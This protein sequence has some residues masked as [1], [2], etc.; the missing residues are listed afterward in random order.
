MVDEHIPSFIVIDDD[1]VNNFIC[2]KIILMMFAGADIKNFTDSRAGLDYILAAYSTTV[3][4]T[5]ILFLD[6]NM[7]GLNGWEVLELF[8]DFPEEV[9]QQI[10]IY[11][12]SSS[13]A[14]DDKL[15]AEQNPLVKG[16]ILKP[17]TQQQ[18]KELLNGNAG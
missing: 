5:S 10:S 11:M 12:F 15:R 13:I 9:K 2:R 18:L 16:F 7:P 3:S 14:M 8:K 6:I 1:P 17:L 4:N